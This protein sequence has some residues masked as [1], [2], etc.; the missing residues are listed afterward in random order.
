MEI[1]IYNDYKQMSNKAANFIINFLQSGQE[2][3]L[4]FAAG[5]TPIKTYQY[6]KEAI[7]KNNN[8]NT[9]QLK[10]VSL[11]EW[12]GLNEKDKGSCENY[13]NKYLFKPLEIKAQ[14][15]HFFDA[16]ANNLKEECLQSDRYISANG[17]IDLLVLGIGLNGHIGFNEPGTVKDFSH[18]VKL[19]SITKSVSKKYFSGK[20]GINRGITLGLKQIMG[21]KNIILLASGKKKAEIIYKALVGQITKEI[22]ASILQE[23]EN[24]YVF[25]DKKAASGLKTI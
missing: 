16:C 15:I 3:L 19:D 6:L 20:R 5:D 12:I 2:M 8:I 10:F 7:D 11:D 22:P 17:P 13:L 25:L 14:N 21:A 18:I 1:N 4:C 24:C 9:D 23:H